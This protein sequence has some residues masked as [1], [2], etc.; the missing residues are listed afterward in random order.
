M[1]NVKIATS[2][3]AL[4]TLVSASAFA[5]SENYDV[6]IF[7]LDDSALVK[8]TDNGQPVD[9]AKVTM[10]GLTSQTFKTSAGGTVT[11]TNTSSS[12]RSFTISVKQPDGS[13]TSTKRYLSVMQ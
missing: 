9:G 12:P 1:K 11:L 4:L 8:V 10:T 7:N 2:M 3:A 6:Q 13:I 5:A